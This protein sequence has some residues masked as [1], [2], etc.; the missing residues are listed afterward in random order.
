MAFAQC[1]GE[2]V[3]RRRKTD[4]EPSPEDRRKAELLEQFRGR[5]PRMVHPSANRVMLAP[6]HVPEAETQP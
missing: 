2:T 5:I 4:G 3:G 6:E 1:K